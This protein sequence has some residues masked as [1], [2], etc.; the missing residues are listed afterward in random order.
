M[1]HDELILIHGNIMVDKKTMIFGLKIELRSCM[2]F[3]SV[4]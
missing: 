2:V 1:L 4:L 3:P